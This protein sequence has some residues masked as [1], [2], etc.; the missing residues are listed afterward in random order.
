MKS[1]MMK[2]VSLGLCLSLSATVAACGG[3]GDPKGAAAP[4]GTTSGSVKVTLDL[5]S[6]GNPK[7][8]KFFG[9]VGD[10]A[11][12]VADARASLESAPATLNKAMNVTGTTDFDTALKTLSGKLKGKVTVSINVTPAGADVSVVPVAGVTLSADEQ[13]M[14]DAYKKV[15][16][17]IAAIPAK[18]APVVAKAIDIATQAAALAVSAKSDFTGM[19]AMKTLPSVIKGFGTVSTA[20]DGIKTDVPVILDKS[21]T[22]TVALK[23]AI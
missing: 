10:L 8:D 5:P 2:M 1:S 6:T 14:V 23:G 21:K 9:D 16:T 11:Q 18:L 22:M 20:V 7:Y 19:A 12:L 17:D 3:A 13:A 15:A 4:T